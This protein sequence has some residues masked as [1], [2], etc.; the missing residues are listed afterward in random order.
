MFNKQLRL[1]VP[2]VTPANGGLVKREGRNRV[3][4]NRRI[5]MQMDGSMPPAH[6]AVRNTPYT[7]VMDGAIPNPPPQCRRSVTQRPRWEVPPGGARPA[8]ERRELLPDG[9]AGVL[10]PLERG[11]VGA[12]ERDAGARK[13]RELAALVRGHGCEQVA[14]RTLAAQER[15]L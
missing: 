13:G 15:G 2:L 9:A 5:C 3:V 11:A 6:R 1:R 4:R 12:R 8:P 7:P 14:L 10:G